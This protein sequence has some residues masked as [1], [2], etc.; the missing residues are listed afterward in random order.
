MKMILSHVEQAAA[1]IQDIVINTPLDYSERLSQKYNAEIYLKREDLQRC[2]SFKVR[3][4]YNK[5]MTLN[6]QERNKGIVCAS[7]GNHAQGV[8]Y[9]CS[10]LNIHGVIFMPLATPLQKINRVKHFGGKYIEVITVGDTY[11]DAYS[12]AIDYCTKNGSTFI[13]PF[14]DYDV[15]CGQATVAKEIYQQLGNKLNIVLTP[16]GGGGLASGVS[17]YLKLK[18]SSTEIIG[19]EPNG[20]PGMSES[21]KQNSLVALKNID[22]FVDGAAVKNVGDLTFNICQKNMQ[23]IVLVPEGKVCTTMIEL[24]Q[25]DGIIVEPAGAL[26][27]SALDNVKSEI[28]HKVVTCIISGG[29]NDILRYPEI[30]ERSL[31]YKG[32]KHY[33]IIEFNQKPGQ[34]KKFVNEALGPN[35]DIVRFEYM[36]KT[37]KESGAALIGIEISKK[38]D[39]EPLL[40]RLTDIGINYRVL[41]NKEMLYNYII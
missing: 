33:L 20:A 25:N 19:V 6:V 29:N 40:Q 34:L 8:A 22:T 26:A 36:K 3:G 28:K 32:L 27:I 5:I 9:S 24:Y 7:A 15:I 14:N 17:A 23:Q 35:D 39:F 1:N 2:R 31:V 37:N 13:H 16:I 10:N 11:D 4:A 30:M 12:K 38:E 18:N 41:S 21:F